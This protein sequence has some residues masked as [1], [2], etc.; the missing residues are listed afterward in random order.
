[1]GFIVVREIEVS[2]ECEFFVSEGG[3]M[4]VWFEGRIVGDFFFR[5]Y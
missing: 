5:D 3:R 1:M 2:F 4:T